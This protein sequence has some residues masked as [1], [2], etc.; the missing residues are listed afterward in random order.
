MQR[1]GDVIAEQVWRFH[2]LLD[3]VHRPVGP[4]AI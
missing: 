2:K 1:V 3:T 4:Q